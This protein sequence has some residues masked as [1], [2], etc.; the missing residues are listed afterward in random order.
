MA[1]KTFYECGCME[2]GEQFFRCEKHKERLVE[3]IQQAGHG[4]MIPDPARLEAI[5]AQAE[6]VAKRICSG[7]LEIV[8]WQNI[9]GPIYDALDS[10]AATIE[11][12]TKEKKEADERVT[13][14]PRI[15]HEG[16]D[17]IN[18]AA[19]LLILRRRSGG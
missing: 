2:Q 11:A 9:V 3:Q 7:G 13:L 5:K 10:Q 4:A 1:S 17:Y 19:T 14:L 18:L 12:L 6:A 15:K 16:V 8:P